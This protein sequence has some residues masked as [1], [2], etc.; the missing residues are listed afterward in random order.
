VIQV[1]EN[2]ADALPG[3]LKMPAEGVKRHPECEKK[4]S[5]SRKEKETPR[6][7]QATKADTTPESSIPRGNK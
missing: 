5:F 3:P 7:E 6:R 2:Q 1:A 4:L